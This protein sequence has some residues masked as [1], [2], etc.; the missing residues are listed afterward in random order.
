MVPGKNWRP[1]LLRF[2]WYL[3][4][5]I[6]TLNILVQ[7]LTKVID[8]S[9]SIKFIGMV[10]FSN[11]WS[12]LNFFFLNVLLISSFEF[13]NHAINFDPIFN[14]AREDYLKIQKVEEKAKW[15]FI[16]NI[17]RK[18]SFMAFNSL[19]VV[20]CILNPSAFLILP[21]IVILAIGFIL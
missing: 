16:R 10:N 20:F 8:P 14:K 19:S 2:I 21:L 9:F 13:F 1:C 4:P 12:V 15:V 7:Y 11:Y 6:T 3:L 17:I 5:I 18:F